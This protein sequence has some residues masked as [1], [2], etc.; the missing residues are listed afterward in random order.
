MAGLNGISAYQKTEQLWNK[1]TNKS[2]TT[3]KNSN[4]AKNQSTSKLDAEIKTSLWK[5]INPKSSLVPS[6]RE[7]VGMSVGDVQLSDKAKE[8][9]SQLK[10]KFG[11]MDFICVSKD[12]MGQVKANAA[13]Y[14]NA[15][16]TVVLIDE[17]KLEMMAN[18]ES[19]RKKY[20]GIIEM[21]QAKL[22]EAKNSLTSS[23]AN[24]KNFG[25]SVNDDGTVNFFATLQKSSENQEKRI[26]EKRAKNK[27]EKAKEKKLNEKK[28]LEKHKEKIEKEKKESE[29]LRE[30][31]DT[32]DVESKDIRH[33]EYV[34]IESNSIED[35][36]NQV[37][38]FA[39]SDSA[40][41]VMTQEEMSL[42]QN[43]D[44]KG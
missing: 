26:Q 23:G 12:M 22:M 10:S 41:S 33:K 5:P 44:F 25:M 7:G 8:Y 42:G 30:K 28:A 1:S 43:I 19:F 15:N 4:V 17:E 11:N 40:N 38:K 37:S 29:K 36:V 9:Y 16:K 39:Y 31:S 21:S 13:A 20:E 24:I 2:T 18:D 35:L 27:A 34:K 14:G 6:E 32:S 3:E